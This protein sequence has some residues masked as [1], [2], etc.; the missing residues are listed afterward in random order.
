MRYIVFAVLF[1]YSTASAQLTRTLQSPNGKVH[2]DSM[3]ANLSGNEK[4]TIPIG[5]DTKQYTV[6]TPVSSTQ[7]ANRGDI[8]YW[9]SSSLNYMSRLVAP[10]ADSFYLGVVTGDPHWN[11]INFLRR[12]PSVSWANE[13][14]PTTIGFPDMILRS[15]GGSDDLLDLSDNSG[16]VL[17][18]FDNTGKLYYGGD[19]VIPLDGASVGH[20]GAVVYDGTNPYAYTNGTSGY[21]LTSTGTST[22]PTFQALASSANSVINNPDGTTS[23]SH[24]YILPIADA[25]ALWL[26]GYTTGG[27]V[28]DIFRIIS[29]ETGSSLNVVKVG[30]HGATTLAPA[31]D[32]V[33]LTITQH[34]GTS[35]ALQIDGSTVFNHSKNLPVARLNSGTSASSSTFWR[36]DGT[37]ATPSSSFT[38]AGTFQIDNIQT[39]STD[40]VLLTNTT[41]ATNTQEQ[42]SPRLRLNG[43]TWT[44]GN[45]TSNTLG[46]IIEMRGQ[47]ST[48]STPTAEMAFSVNGA[49][50]TA[51]DTILTLWRDASSQP[52]MSFGG[53]SFSGAL[54]KLGIDRTTSGSG[55]DATIFGQNS[56][57]SNQSAGNLV[58]KPGAPTGNHIGQAIT[59]Q[60]FGTGSSGSTV[61]PTPIQLAKFEPTSSTAVKETI[62]AASSTTGTIVIANSATANTTSLV[63]TQPTSARTITFPDAS[64]TVAL[65]SG[66]SIIDVAD[67]GTG[68]G[69]LASNGILYGNGTGAVQVTS[70]VTGAVLTTNTVTGVPSLTRGITIDG[71]SSRTIGLSAGATNGSGLTIAAGDAASGATDASGGTLTLSGG[72]ATG[73]GGS[74]IGFNLTASGGASGTATRSATQYGSLSVDASAVTLSLGRS[75]ALRTGQLSLVSGN[76]VVLT[77]APT[78]SSSSRTATF[79]DATGTVAYT[80]IAHGG[81]GATVGATSNI[82]G[83]AGGII[84]NLTFF[85]CPEGATIGAAAAETA[86]EEILCS[87]AATLSNYYVR[88]DAPGG[89]ETTSFTVMKNGVATAITCTVTGAA[90]TANDLTHTFT[91]AAGDRLSIKIITSTA[92]ATTKATWGLRSNG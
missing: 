47:R 73:S 74:Q 33:P 76:T 91:V 10:P 11:T 37:W 2:K 16:T 43:Q 89:T 26:G 9:S 88:C 48:T 57:G 28:E 44:N 31:A 50:S 13:V 92:S 70:S 58:L 60:S 53:S 8:P 78:S 36:G 40:A 67:G 62:G 34:S 4:T 35:D 30:V 17:S 77:L 15:A 18:N 66:G 49:G 1:V 6:V 19:P 25:S 80:D 84:A 85:T 68:V 3:S 12:D 54:L 14:L 51:F 65:T 22:V 81:T 64:G 29:N 86:T 20:A 71:S 82:G 46:G 24:N 52:T 32:E 23:L 90:T 83:A 59:L 45:T 5:I 61:N 69:T 42:W 75:S 21:V 38:T 56:S 39:V 87:N 41:A 27:S 7:T 79:P 55:G 63:A 72:D